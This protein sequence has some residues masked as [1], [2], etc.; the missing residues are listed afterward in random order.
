MRNKYINGIV[1]FALLIL[2]SGCQNKNPALP[3]TLVNFAHLQHLSEEIMLNDRTMTIVHI[4]AEYPDYHWVTD[5]DEGMTCVDDVARAAV[6]YLRHYKYRGSASSREQ[7]KK[8]L[9]FILHMQAPNGL[10]YNFMFDDR[11]INTTHQNSVPVASWWSWRAIWALAEA[12]EILKDASPEYGNRLSASIEKTFPALDSLLQYYPQT[13]QIKGMELPTWLPYQTAADQ[14]AVIIMA[15]LPYYQVSANEKVLGYIQRFGEGMIQMQK[16]DSAVVPFGAFLSWENSWHAYGN[17]QA[18]ALLR[19]AAARNKAPFVRAAL[20]EVKFF[21]PFLMEQNF[22]SSFEVILQGEGYQFA[23]I[24]SYPQI[25]YGLRPMVW[26]GLRAQEATGSQRFA[27]LAGEMAC[28]LLGKN[29]VGLPM[30]DYRTGRCFDGIN[31]KNSINRNSGA[32]STIE[33]LLTLLEVEQN[34]TAKK[35]VWDYFRSRLSKIE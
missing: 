4:Y 17:S 31:D 5:P 1:L 24:K 6:L 13:R 14:A 32:E 34:P 3:H 25:A 9:E 10:F 7:A 12:A 35:M 16:G 26:A 28:W 19:F 2:L 21:Y 11:S 22:W 20:K 29:A 15:L 8:M 23:N 27:R 18:C 30:Y 33:A